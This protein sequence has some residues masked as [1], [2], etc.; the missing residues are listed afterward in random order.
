[1]DNI[2]E[3][4]ENFSLKSRHHSKL[5]NFLFPELKK[6]SKANILEFG[7][8]EKGMSTE[9]FLKHSEPHQCKVFSIDNVDYKSKFNNQNWKFILSRDDNFDYIKVQI[10]DVFGLILLDTIHEA[11]HV[12]KIIY[13]YFDKLELNS[14]FFIDDINWIPYLKD[15]EKNRFYNEINNYETFQK[16]LEIYNSNRDNLSMEFTFEGTGM[17]KIKKLKSEPLKPSK[18]I[19]HRQSS[20][21]NILR[22]I[23]KS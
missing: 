8:S 10:P 15:A 13:Y 3:F 7:V 21:K 22:K 20:V 14:C 18:K 5:I 23:L 19:N 17:C 4:I 1:M 2:L 6:I 9:L 12:E 16:L 11:N